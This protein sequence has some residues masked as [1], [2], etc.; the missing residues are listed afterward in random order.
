MTA[1]TIAANIHAIAIDGMT[2][3]RNLILCLRKNIDKNNWVE[4]GFK[5][6]QMNCKMNTYDTR[7]QRT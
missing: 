5:S 6:I 3:N 1:I 7:N 2:I 4:V